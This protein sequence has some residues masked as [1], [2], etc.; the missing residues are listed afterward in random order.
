MKGDRRRIWEGIKTLLIVLLACSA[1]YLAGRTLFPRQLSR[2]FTPS[3]QS[4]TAESATVGLSSQTLRPAAL[5][6]TWEDKRYALLPHQDDQELYTQVSAL[7]AEA[8]SDAG[9]P[10]PITR[11]DW[12]QALLSPGLY[13]EYL[14]PMPLDTLSLWLS[15]QSNRALSGAWA[16]RLCVNGDQLSYQDR[17]GTYYSCALSPDLAGALSSLAA[18]LSSNGARFAGET[19]NY[20]ALRW[21]TPVLD[22][23]PSLPQLL[24]QDPVWISD[25]G[26]PGDNLARV[27]RSL[28]FHPQTN[29]LY[30]I[31]GGW[32]IND[33]GETLRIDSASTLTYR[34]TED[35]PRF[36]VGSDPLD[37]TRALAES[38]VGAMCGD[39]R[40]YLREV[41]QDGGA[42]LITYG[43]AY[44]GASIQVGREGW[45]A[46]FVVRNGA[47][48]SF[49][50][51][52]RHY[53]ALEDDPALLLPQE[54]AA[55]ALEGPE[56]QALELLYADDG[57]S[58]NLTPFWAVR[59]EGR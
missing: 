25:T 35:T 48:E 5:S 43:Y 57:Q 24:A 18:P 2:L 53:T 9:A 22:L 49:T 51:K 55:A 30:A 40:L 20:G 47:V 12:E 19:E 13:C 33:G 56:E 1:V 23:T 10:A 32:A 44:R 45:C 59:T 8:L 54:Q 31:T 21:D 37:A 26:T 36:P 29:P 17:D 58:Q 3:H 42:T 46:Q 11:R 50:L 34:R 4:T 39:A 15:G 7:L 52:P 16:Q 38:S 14:S 41:R 6:V 28:S 27:L